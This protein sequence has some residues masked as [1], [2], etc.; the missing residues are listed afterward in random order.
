MQQTHEQRV[1]QLPTQAGRML[2]L[3]GD[4]SGARRK[5]TW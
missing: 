3:V 1:H 2:G 4:G 5:Q